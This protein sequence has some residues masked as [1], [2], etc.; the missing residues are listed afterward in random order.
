MISYLYICTCILKQRDGEFESGS[1]LIIN[2][3]RYLFWYSRTIF[4]SGLFTCLFPEL[5][6]EWVLIGLTPR[7]LSSSLFLRASCH[8]NIQPFSHERYVWVVR[9]IQWRRDAHME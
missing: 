2:F 1:Y 6:V 8:W 4:N 3:K 5:I 9:K 7:F